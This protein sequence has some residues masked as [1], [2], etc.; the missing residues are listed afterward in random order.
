MLSL[1]RSLPIAM[2]LLLIIFF[3]ACGSNGSDNN[4][5]TANSPMGTSTMM[6]KETPT[7]ASMNHPMMPTANPNAFIHTMQ[8]TINGKLVTVLTTEKG[9]MLYYRLSDPAPASSCSGGC[10][11]T[12]PPLIATGMD[13][14]TS[15]ITLPHKLT[16]YKTANGNQV[17]Y[18]G[19]PLYTYVG[20]MAPGQFT[21]RGMG[22]VWYLVGIGL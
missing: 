22:N 15:S 1:R 16:V 5:M 4:S 12:W 14:I 21:G 20:D 7:S 17:E 8:V 19:H 3:A 9:V 11:M 13:T 6:S 2:S 10:A 18:D